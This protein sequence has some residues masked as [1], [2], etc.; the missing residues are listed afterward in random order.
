[1][2]GRYYMGTGGGRSRPGGHFEELAKWDNGITTC[3]GGGSAK[4]ISVHLTL[5]HDYP[6]SPAFA[7][8][9]S[10]NL[11]RKSED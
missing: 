7:S 5:M 6:L 2:T 4:R 8:K 11:R 3:G 1:M 10:I 9:S